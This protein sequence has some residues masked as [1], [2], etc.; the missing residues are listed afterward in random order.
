MKD[1]NKHP[2]DLE[3][4]RKVKTASESEKWKWSWNTWSP[5]I[6]LIFEG[7][8]SVESIKCPVCAENQL[9]AYFL[10]VDIAAKSTEEEHRPVYVADRW[11]GC[12]NCQTQ[13][14]D[15]GE[16]PRWVRKEDIV[17]ASERLRELSER[18]LI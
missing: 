11:F 5:A 2:I 10:T 4:W 18:R 1:S 17:W 14:R 13:V 16:L 15:R 12:R 7:R 3:L 8:V 9:Y 6:A